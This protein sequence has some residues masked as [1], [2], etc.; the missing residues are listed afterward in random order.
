MR[1]FLLTIV[2]AIAVGCSAARP[3]P[4]K[5]FVITIDGADKVVDQ[6]RKHRCDGNWN[7][8]DQVKD[9]EYGSYVMP[10]FMVHEAEVKK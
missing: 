6:T 4:P 3:E 7:F 2:L 9:D 10:E 1:L 8:C 5:T